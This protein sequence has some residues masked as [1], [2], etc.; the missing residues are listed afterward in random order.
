MADDLLSLREAAAQTG[1]SASHLRLLARTGKLE[2][3]LI[4]SYWVTTEAA[5]RAYLAN[6]ALRKKDPYKRRRGG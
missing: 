6:E 3:R 4:G 1:I 2:A 5:V